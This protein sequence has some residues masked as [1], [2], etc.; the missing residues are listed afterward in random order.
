MVRFILKRIIY[1]L[2]VLFAVAILIFT[3]MYFVPGDPATAIAGGTATEKELQEI[4]HSL[5]LDKGYFERLYI[6]LSGIITQGSFGNSYIRG[7]SVVGDLMQRLP[8]TLTIAFFSILICVLIGMPIGIRAAVRANSWE[9]RLSMFFSMIGVSIPNFWL[10]ILL[11]M[12]FS[13]QLKWLPSSGATSWKNFV[14]PILSCAIAGIAGMTRLS[15]SSMLEVIRSDYVTTARAKGVSE[16][17]VIYKHALPNALI[18]IITSIGNTFGASMGGTVVIETIFSIPGIGLY[19]VTAI[20]Q[21]DYNCVQGSIIVFALI[22]SLVILIVDILYAIA[23]PRI[24]AQYMSQN[25]KR[26]QNNKEE[27][28]EKHGT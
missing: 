2:P 20:F 3:L 6:F 12:F 10:G 25:K 14:L 24:K 28:E 19:M 1:M 5:G 8:N 22:F 11:A 18:P 16:H 7:S 23:D 27:G 15:R 13:L 21:R 17:N 9:D 4:R 26:K